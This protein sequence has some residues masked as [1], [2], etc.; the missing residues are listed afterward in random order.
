ME[1]NEKLDMQL[2]KQMKIQ[3]SMNKLLSLNNP[4]AVRHMMPPLF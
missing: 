2:L 4:R 1:K 3:I